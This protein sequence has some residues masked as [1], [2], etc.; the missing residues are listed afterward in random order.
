[1]TWKTRCNVVMGTVNN[2]AEVVHQQAA[3]MH[4]MGENLQHV[5]QSVQ[6]S[7]VVTYKRFMELDPPAFTSKADPEAAE[8]WL[9]EMERIFPC[10]GCPRREES[11][12][13]HLSF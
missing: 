7:S 4:Q 1:M 12:F 10:S 13:W 5:A 3:A 9:R 6:N 8:S 11:G 2:L